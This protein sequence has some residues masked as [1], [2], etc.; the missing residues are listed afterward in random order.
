[1]N[2][3]YQT[4]LVLG[5]GRSGRAA[6]ALLE[7]EGVRVTVAAGEQEPPPAELR[8]DVAVVSPGFERSHPWVEACRRARVPVI[9]ELEL[10]ARFAHAPILAVTGS[11]GKSSVVK[12]LAESLDRAGLKALPCGNYGR[13]L[14]D[15]VRESADWLV[16]EV[17]SFQLE[18]VDRFRPRV[19]VVLN[20]LPNHLDRHGDMRTYLALKARIFENS[21]PEDAC[22]APAAQAARLFAAAP[23]ARG[24]RVSFGE[25][26]A[27]YVYAQG[28]VEGPDGF[29]MDVRGTW[30][31]DPVRGPG[32]AAP[33]AAALDTLGLPPT[34]AEDAA[35]DFAPLPHR[36]EVV[37]VRG[38]VR[39][40]DDSKATNLAALEA[41]VRAQ[42]GPVRLI[43]GG[44]MKEHG[45]DG[46]ASLMRAR[47][48]AAYLIGEAEEALY[49]AWRESCPCRRC[50]TLDEA[51]RAAAGEARRGDT[52]LLSPGGTSFDQ[53]S[54][55]EERGD[56]FRALVEKS[57]E[58]EGVS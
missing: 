41:G 49:A 46:L 48:A 15:A 36:T 34:A 22:L 29:R 44:R 3:P 30:F 53:F 16:A 13:P 37:A 42:P 21:G 8:A 58:P 39:F 19:A 7:A 45:A 51:V 35:R 24:R 52:V 20:V 27:D 43:A 5:W 4:A 47:V 2:A 56:R 26:E 6:A 50:S 17:S 12:W 11:N 55:F 40:V 14:S 32:G 23:G 10:G 57:I 25:T 9:G 31:E 38:G 18:T 33:V 28:R 54:D 1:M